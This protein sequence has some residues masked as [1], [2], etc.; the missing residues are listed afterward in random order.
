VPETSAC[1]DGHHKISL[2]TDHLRINKFY[3]PDDPSFKSVYPEIERMARN[4][5]DMIQRRRNP[6]ALPVNQS[7]T[8]GD[9]QKCLQEMR[10]ANPRD[11]L[12]DVQTHKGKR[13][14][15]TCEWIL[16]RE[17]FSAWCF[18]NDSQLLRLTGPPGIGKTMMSTFLIEL[19][20]GKVER[21]DDHML[22]YFFCDDKIQDRKMPTAIIRSLVWQ[23]LLQRNELFEHMR[24]DYEKHIKGRI[25]IDLFDNFTTLW[26]I[27]QDML[28]DE[29]AGDI[30]IVID[31]LDECDKST[32][33]QLL[34]ALRELFQAPGQLRR[35][36][37]LLITCRQKISDIEYE[38]HGAGKL[39]GLDSG[40]VNTDL[41]EYI[42]FKVAEL[43]TRRN[44]SSTLKYDVVNALKSRAGGTFL[45]VSLMISELKDTPIYDV[46]AKL[47]SL[48]ESLE[49]TYITILNE[50]IPQERR[51][52]A[53]FLLLSM[54]S[55][56]RPLKRKEIATSFALWK[57][58]LVVSSRDIHV[59]MDI[60]SLCSSIIYQD[61][62]GNP[63]ETTVTFC[64]QSLKDFLLDDKRGSCD[65]WYHSSLDVANL[66]MFEV[67][68]R[69]LSS[70]ELYNGNL[71]NPHQPD[72]FKSDSSDLN[73]C[74]QQHCFLEY[75]SGMWEYHAIASYPALLGR[76]G[77]DVAKAPSL[78]DAW[79]VRAAG[80]GQLEVFELLC[81]N[82]ANPNSVDTHDQTPL[83]WAAKFGHKDVVR[84]LLA[85]ENVNIDTRNEWGRTPFSW[86][87]HNGHI[88]IVEMLLATGK[89]ELN[90]RDNLR[91]TPLCRA[92]RNGQESIVARLLQIEEI[93]ADP[94]D[95]LGRT[96]LSL[97]ADG[98]YEG[99]VGRL[100]ALDRV[101]VDSRDRLGRTPLS[102]AAE[103][104]RVTVI[105][106]LLSTEKAD[107]SAKDNFG[108]MPSWW[109]AENGHES[110]VQLLRRQYRNGSVSDPILFES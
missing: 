41:F 86:A 63:E 21:S 57:N 87:A 80:E 108:Q 89:I 59:Y 101:E 82:H 61:A 48:P 3:G 5:G 64:H 34:L 15:H 10:V 29:R 32:R 110:V 16:R 77:I 36:V 6:T 76:L 35:K 45:W 31:A 78:R 92:A 30:F 73:A 8:I 14:G 7:A 103:N 60:C 94:V 53:R 44:Y 70:D 37:K 97:A 81:D 11:I 93:E 19:L 40:E 23:L 67:C 85:K 107:H 71:I 42:D 99:I 43:A 106:L 18:G 72:A 62:A 56:Q 75:A 20:K 4:A 1:I 9:L 25:F 50:N 83:L 109:A 26:R 100:L 49:E 28:Q 105:Q 17:E 33:K 84:L 52:E 13:V 68:W 88:E 102:W 27:F 90:S 69:Y 98:G 58:G 12:A 51:E 74:F 38:L 39:L 79:L 65:A 22:A 96:P 24:P 91:R 104:G 95:S 66:V 55:A 2:N 54:A 47:N 46:P